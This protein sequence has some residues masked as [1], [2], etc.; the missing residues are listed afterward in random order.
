MLQLLIDG[1]N[2]IGQMP[3]MSLADFDDEQKLVANLRNYVARHLR[4]KSSGNA[5]RV[6]VVF[7]SGTPGGKS[8]ALSGGGV[9]AIFAADKHTTA[10]RVLI[11]RM[12][13]LKRPQE[14]T[15]VSSDRS[16]QQEAARRRMRIVE[17][18]D[19]A[20]TLVPPEAPLKPSPSD[21]S[22]K[23]EREDDVKGWLD[24]FKKK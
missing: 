17:S 14:W 23:P 15:L 21:T 18:A 20:R 22:D 3:G 11:E 2:L 9:E 24:Q 12:R 8:Q 7:D 19:F 16:V 10:D 6:V 1:H 5:A 4:K 13:A